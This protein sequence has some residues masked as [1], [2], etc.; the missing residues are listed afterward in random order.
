MPTVL[1]DKCEML[2]KT[3]PCHIM[4]AGVKSIHLKATEDER[5]HSGRVWYPIVLQLQILH[6][7][8]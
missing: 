2:E 5:Q 7:F 8:Q 3:E 1:V 6:P 4:A